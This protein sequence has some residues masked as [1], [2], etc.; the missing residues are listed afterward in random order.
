[1]IDPGRDNPFKNI[2]MKTALFAV[3]LCCAWANGSVVATPISPA[4]EDAVDYSVGLYHAAIDTVI[5]TASAMMDPVAPAA[6]GVVTRINFDPDQSGRDLARALARSAGLQVRR[7][8]GTGFAAVPALR[9]ASAAQIRVFLDGMPLNSAQTGEV[10]LSRLP[11]DQLAAAEVHRGVVPA[12]WG[13]MGGA[14]A[15]NL[16]TRDDVDGSE[17][18]NSQIPF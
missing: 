12:G 3:V 13:G 5:I 16:L 6:G 7:Y 9:G 1:M 15:V 10:D 4:A 18:A 11:V 14:G 17:V 2:Q 8:G